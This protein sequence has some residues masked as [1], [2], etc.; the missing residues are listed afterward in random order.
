MSYQDLIDGFHKKLAGY[1]HYNEKIDFQVLQGR[2][3]GVE[4][5]SADFNYKLTKIAFSVTNEFEE[6]AISPLGGDFFIDTWESKVSYLLDLK[7]NRRKVIVKFVNKALDSKETVLIVTKTNKVLDDF[8]KRELMNEIKNRNEYLN[9]KVVRVGH[10]VNEDLINKY[11]RLNLEWCKK[12]KIKKLKS[13]KER[14]KKS[15]IFLDK[16]MDILDKINLS[17]LDNYSDTEINELNKKIENKF[18]DSFPEVKNIDTLLNIRKRIIKA[19]RAQKINEKIGLI[20]KK[21]NEIEKTIIE[22][23]SIV[24]ATTVTTAMRN[25]IFYNRF[26]NVIVLNSKDPNSA[27]LFLNIGLAN[28]RVLFEDGVSRAIKDNGRSIFSDAYVKSKVK[29]KNK[30]KSIGIFRK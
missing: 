20:D 11:K 3:R 13:K 10:N 23:A 12:A 25:S 28:K 16:S 6:K 1:D 8:L 17:N 9:G 27:I 29:K 7:K 24:I 26:D 5:G 21:V 14:L 19:H 2:M 4:H 30:Q 22:R 18:N 15:K